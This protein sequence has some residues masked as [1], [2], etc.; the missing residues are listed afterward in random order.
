MA[1]GAPLR[2]QLRR[3]IFWS[4]YVIDRMLATSLGRPTSIPDEEIDI[5]VPFDRDVDSLTNDEAT[6]H[7]SMTS[8]LHLIDLVRIVSTIRRRIYRLDEFRSKDPIDLLRDLDEWDARI[9]K[10]ASDAACTKIPCCTKDW[11]L[12]KSLDAR[13]CLLRPLTADSRSADPGH[14][15]LLAQYAADAC[16]TQ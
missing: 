2:S 14:L 12:S 8:S 10:R 4:A 16:E 11:F 7:T 6:G 13:L 1:Q 9:P 5:E 15:K 3:R